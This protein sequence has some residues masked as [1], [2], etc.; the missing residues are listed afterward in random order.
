MNNQLIRMIREGE[1]Q[2]QDFK[3][4]ITDSRKIAKSL[5]AFA[6]SEGGSLLIG[7]KDN[8]NIVGV[9]SDEEY[10]M[11]E[12]AARIYSKPPVP[13]ST[14]QWHLEGK[15]VLQVTV[16]PSTQKPH[17]AKDESGKWMAFV[18]HKDENRLAG[19]V[20][21][22]VWNKQKSKV[23]ITIRLSDAEKF[24]LKYLDENQF[25]SVSGFARKASLPYR[26]AE[27]L[28]ADFI[29]LGI[30]QPYYGDTHVLYQ[31]NREFDVEGWARKRGY[32]F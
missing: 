13:F 11:V 27:Q 10:Y 25:I 2:K 12:S 4:C 8:G 30:V 9:Q 5:V 22:E 14:R 28:L 18:R 6:N 16:E 20:M 3:F 26:Q 29:V 32:E 21:I 17:Y 31:F 24:L 23:G 15:T 7:V 19:K 1:H